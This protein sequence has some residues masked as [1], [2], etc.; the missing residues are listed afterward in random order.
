MIPGMNM[1]GLDT[2]DGSQ[3]RKAVGKISDSLLVLVLDL[4]DAMA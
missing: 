2:V 4:K 3:N 1:T